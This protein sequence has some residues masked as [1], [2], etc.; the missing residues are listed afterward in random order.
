MK[1]ILLALCL[2]VGIF[3]TT[4]ANADDLKIGVVNITR[5]HQESAVMK[6]LNK[7][8]D[9]A[10]EEI[11]KSVAEKRKVFEKREAEIKKQEEELKAKQTVMD[12][13]ALIKEA[14]KIQGEFQKFQMDLIEQDKST[15]KRISLVEKAFTEAVRTVQDDYFDRI[16]RKIGAEKKFSLV[17]NSQTAIVMDK[18]LDI[19]TEVIDALNDDIKEMKL[20]IK[21]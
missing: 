17:L 4:N 9:A 6:S 5:I 1:K 12:R 7:Q 16:V 2:Y 11:K 14:Q 18:N 13:D 19:T 15:E 20:N 21:G 8:K 3:T 10:I